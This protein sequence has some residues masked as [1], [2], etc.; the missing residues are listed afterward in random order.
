MKT[1][2]ILIL[3]ASL[4]G[5]RAERT[6]REL[7]LEALRPSPELPGEIQSGPQGAFLAIENTSN[8]TLRVPLFVLDNP[9]VTSTVYAVRGEIQHRNVAGDAFLEMW[10]V[11]G[12]TNA[13]N[14]GAR[15][16]SRTL[17]AAGPMK[18]ISGTS[19]WRP[20]VLPFNRS[21]STEPPSRLEANLVLPGPG[22][23]HL[24]GFALVEDYDLLAPPA[25]AWWSERTGG[26][27]GGI[28][29]ASLGCLAGLLGSLSSRRKARAFVLGAGYALVA[30]GGASAI[31]GLAAVF[32]AQPYA[33]WFPLTLGGVLILAI[34][35]FRLREMRASYQQG[36]LRQMRAI[37]ALRA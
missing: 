33:V 31:A 28:G 14:G 4:L 8:A 6:I 32:L 12:G 25:G 2:Y 20:I 19:D 36:E 3:S 29:G 10:N 35:P 13:P 22:V 16:F 23:V 11:F 21:G 1:H 24:R 27:V 17:S 9:G 15:Y 34:L 18:K 37:D 30:L 5:S 26:L 7:D